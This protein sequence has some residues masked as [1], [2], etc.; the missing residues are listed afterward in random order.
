[1]WPWILLLGVTNPFTNAV[2]SL[3][4]NM[5][6]WSVVHVVYC[7]DREISQEKQ[8]KHL[9]MSIGYNFSTFLWSGITA[10]LFTNSAFV[11]LLLLGCLLLFATLGTIN[12]NAAL[13]FL[14]CIICIVFIELIIHVEEDF[15]SFHANN[16]FCCSPEDFLS[17]CFNISNQMRTLHNS[18]LHQK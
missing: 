10:L 12:S 13:T 11:L 3:P 17:P 16:L 2:S 1:M 6:P 5:Q 8:N 7:S 14:F 15:F 9:P 4:S 18:V